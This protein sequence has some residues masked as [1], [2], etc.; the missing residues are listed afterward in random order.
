MYTSRNFS[1]EFC[2]LRISL[3][4][5]EAD[6]L[7][8]INKFCNSAIFVS[9]SFNSF[10]KSCIFSS[11]SA[12]VSPLVSY[13]TSPLFVTSSCFCNSFSKFVIILFFPSISSVKF[14]N[15]ADMPA[16][17]CSKS[18][19][20]SFNL[21]I[22]VVF[23]SSNFWI[24]SL[25]S[26]NT[27]F[28]SLPIITSFFKLYICAWKSSFLDLSSSYKIFN[29]SCCS[30]NIAPILLVSFTMFFSLSS[31]HTDS[32]AFSSLGV[33]L[34]SS[35]LLI[36]TSN[37]FDESFKF[38]FSISSFETSSWLF[39]SN[40]LNSSIFLFELASSSF[41]NVFNL[42]IPCEDEIISFSWSIFSKPASL[43]RS[44]KSFNSSL[45]LNI[46]FSV[47]LN[48]T[49]NSSICF[50]CS[51]FDDNNPSNLAR[52]CSFSVEMRRYS[53]SNNA[54][55]F[56]KLLFSL[57]IFWMIL[58]FS[59]VVVDRLRSIFLI[60]SCN[61]SISL[62][63]S[64]IIFSFSAF[65]DDDL[66]SK[67]FSLNSSSSDLVLFKS[68]SFFSLLIRFSFSS[69]P[70]MVILS[71][72]T[73]VFLLLAISSFSS[74]RFAN[75]CSNSFIFNSTVSF[76]DILALTVSMFSFSNH[77]NFSC[78]FFICSLSSVLSLFSHCIWKSD[79]S[80]DSSSF[81]CN[82]SHWLFAS[83]FSMFCICVNPEFSLLI[84]FT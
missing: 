1:D 2:K 58:S 47:K 52:I 82:R 44:S 67:S 43:H 31:S 33:I 37:N 48:L 4:L 17:F 22:I 25:C 72:F 3:S 32:K 35:T 59:E 65:E 62:H 73:S 66:S 83:I 38:S 71:W 54:K 30:F 60:C 56:S 9:F 61:S 28:C 27:C 46:S 14:W 11:S 84:S 63:L 64:K 23:C 51:P 15:L 40:S 70:S 45:S 69:R 18:S 49:F 29:S 41:K 75:F 13:R 55:S 12:L 50:K 77:D 20:F 68:T 6:S 24:S 81:S 10:F 26:S 39:A 7:A 53:L 8:S 34:S 78:R 80:F 36:L 79:F 16:S 57:W 42:L 74:V 21:S 19:I 76:S 5:P